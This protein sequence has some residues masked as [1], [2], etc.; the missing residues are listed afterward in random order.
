M[1]T[2]SDSHGTEA[3]DKDPLSPVTRS[4]S[5]DCHAAVSAKEDGAGGETHDSDDHASS[6]SSTSTPSGS[7]STGAAKAAK[8]KSTKD[9]ETPA[10]SA[11]QGKLEKFEP[12]AFGSL[13]EHV[14]SHDYP[15]H[16]ATC[17]AC[18]F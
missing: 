17:G 13:E 5:A 8:S 6:E 14:R 18:K 1:E 11:A 3:S 12:H 15:A 4:P 10:G 16:V 2:Q 7:D 9:T